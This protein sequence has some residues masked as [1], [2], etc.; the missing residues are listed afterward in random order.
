MRQKQ[1]RSLEK[2]LEKMNSYKEELMAYFL[3]HYHD[4]RPEKIEELE[5]L[6]RRIKD[7]EDLW[8]MISEE[9]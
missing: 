3:E 1:L 8:L 7:K 9:K 2:D 4:Y 6:K 5:D